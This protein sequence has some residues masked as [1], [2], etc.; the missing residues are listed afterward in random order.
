MFVATKMINA[1][2][3]RVHIT[4]LCVTSKKDG[5]V[6]GLRTKIHPF[7]K[8]LAVFCIGLTAGCS[9]F[10]DDLIIHNV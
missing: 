2:T 5:V 7:T 6:T 1:M 3:C 10:R 4:L 8:S 9:I